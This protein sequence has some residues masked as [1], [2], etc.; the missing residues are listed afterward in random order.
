MKSVKY[1][2]GY[3]ANISKL[4]NTRNGRLTGLK[5][6]DCHVLIQRILPIGMRGYVDKE[7][8]TTL[9]EL[10]NFFQDLCSKTLRRSELEELE[11]CVIYIL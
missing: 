5:S 9:F 10:G 7:I 6:H 1:P 8:S 4:V 2:D 3:A 11:E